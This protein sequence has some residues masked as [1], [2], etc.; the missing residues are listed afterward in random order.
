MHILLFKVTEKQH[1]RL[2]QHFHLPIYES[3]FYLPNAPIK[4]NRKK[5]MKRKAER[6][7][8]IEQE[9]K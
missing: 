7:K 5:I 4:I 6:I 2:E 3:F 9:I 8:C 1:H